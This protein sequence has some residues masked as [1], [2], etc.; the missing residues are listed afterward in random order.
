M[1]ELKWKTPNSKAIT[2]NRLTTPNIIT[3]NLTMAGTHLKV[4]E[5]VNNLRVKTGGL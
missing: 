2:D 3:K 5:Q 1:V 4:V